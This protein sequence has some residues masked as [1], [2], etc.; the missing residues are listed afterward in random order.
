MRE[1]FQ[2][3]HALD[4]PITPFRMKFP[5]L[6][7]EP[8]VVSLLKRLLDIKYAEL[9]IARHADAARDEM[10]LV[11]GE[12]KRP[13]VYVHMIRSG[14]SKISS[15]RFWIEDVSHSAP[16]ADDKICGSLRGE[17]II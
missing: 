6:I 1:G 9:V 3:L 5:A 11:A 8:L 17:S 2:I 10:R 16:Q 15:R 14:R 13:F 12:L 7:P 4:I